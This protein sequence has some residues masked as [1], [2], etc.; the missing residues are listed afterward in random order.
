MVRQPSN[1]TPICVALSRRNGGRP[2]F[3]VPAL[4]DGIQSFSDTTKLEPAGKRCNL[5]DRL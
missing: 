5:T 4:I 2:L 3:F 1:R